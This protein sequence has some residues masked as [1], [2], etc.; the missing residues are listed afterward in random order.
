[1]QSGAYTHIVDERQRRLANALPV[2]SIPGLTPGP[3]I[4]EAE[5]PS[6]VAE[7]KS[8]EVK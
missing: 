5:T 2:P 3:V 7:S 1:M 6:P 8:P 4:V